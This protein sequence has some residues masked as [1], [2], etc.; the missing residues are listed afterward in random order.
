MRPR[1]WVPAPISP[2]VKRSFGLVSADQ[3]CDGK[4]KGAVVATAVVLRK[5]RR[6]ERREVVMGEFSPARRNP[7]RSNLDLE[8]V[9]REESSQHRANSSPWSRRAG[10]P[11]SNGLGS[12]FN[13]FQATMPLRILSTNNLSEVV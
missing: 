2:I 11:E 8:T 6:V 1:P 7:A 10:I 4:M 13:C 3:M 12:V 5:V 9:R